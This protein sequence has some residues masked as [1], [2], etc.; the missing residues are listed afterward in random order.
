MSSRIAPSC[1]VAVAL[2]LSGAAAPRPDAT[3]RP[4]A[5]REDD[6]RGTYRLRG[7]AR[8]SAQP[9]LDGA[10]EVF[11]DA[12]LEPGGGAGEVRARI[13]AE[14]QACELLARRE[15]GGALAFAPGQRCDLAVR[16]EG[17]RG[18]VEARLRSGKGTLRGGLLALELSFELSGTVSLRTS[19]P[20]EILG[21]TVDVPETWSPELPV[22]GEARATAEGRRDESRASGG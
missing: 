5:A 7:T 13:S 17:A 8:I 4:P 2:V 18:R 21:R 20:V 14:G 15:S 16:S 19:R 1:I 12:L 22:R 6:V 11:A 9:M 10:E 3:R